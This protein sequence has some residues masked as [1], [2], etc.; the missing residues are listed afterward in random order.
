MTGD[1][2][3]Y[4][5]SREHTTWPPGEH[6]QSLEVVGSSI[7]HR[8]LVSSSMLLQKARSFAYTAYLGTSCRNL[9]LQSAADGDKYLPYIVE[10]QRIAE[11]IDALTGEPASAGAARLRTLNEEYAALKSS[12]TFPLSNSRKRIDPFSGPG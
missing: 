9:A 12:V 5:Q 3:R 2:R 4:G 6:I 11:G 1:L 7:S 8:W 10:A